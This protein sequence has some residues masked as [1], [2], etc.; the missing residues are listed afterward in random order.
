M[1]TPTRSTPGVCRT[2]CATRD[3]IARA[4]PPPSVGVSSTPVS[5]PSSST[6]DLMY[7]PPMSIHEIF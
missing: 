4:P 2:S 5:T 7:V 1:E 6:P 3:S